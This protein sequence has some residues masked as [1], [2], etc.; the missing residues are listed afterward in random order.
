MNNM[1]KLFTKY[2]SRNDCLDMFAK[3]NR[4]NVITHIYTSDGP[5]Q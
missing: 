4:I 2:T 1:L 5:S 3:K